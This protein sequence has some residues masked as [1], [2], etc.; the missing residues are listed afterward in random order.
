MT[1]T[2]R[3]QKWYSDTTVDDHYVLVVEPGRDYLTHVT[4]TSGKST[5]IA[6]SILTVIRDQNATDTITAVGCDS[7]N[8]N[9]GCKA[10]VICQMELSLGRPLNWF[11]CILHTNKNYLSDIHFCI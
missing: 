6:N 4:P 5:D 9:T 8:T 11:I 2:K 10:G 1:K 7:T 3:E